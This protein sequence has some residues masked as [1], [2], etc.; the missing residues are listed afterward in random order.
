M[1]V[2]VVSNLYPPIAFGGYEILCQQIVELLRGRGLEVDVLTSRFRAEDAPA[3]PRVERSLELTTDFPRPGEDVRFVDF[4]L[5]TI[6]RVARANEAL[7]GRALDRLSLGPMFAARRR[8]V[9][10]CY[11][12]NDEHPKQFRWNGA[13]S[14]ARER[15]R[16]IA[17]RTLWRKATLRDLDPVPTAVISQA[18]KDA[19]LG[20]GTPI[21]HAQVIHQGIPLNRF[22]FDPAPRRDGDPLR[23]LYVGQLSELKGVHTLIRAMGLL[24][25]G[26]GD[27]FELTVV[28][29]GVPEYVARL[30]GLVQ[31]YGLQGVVRFTGR[32]A[33]ADVAEAYRSHHV[34]VFATEGREAF[35]LSHLEAMASGCAVVSTTR[36]GCA[37]LVRDGLNAREFEAGN[38]LHLA[39][40]LRLLADDEEARRQ[41]VTNGRAWV[42]AHHDLDHYCARLED[43]MAR[44]LRLGRSSF[45]SGEG[46]E[47]CPSEAQGE[48]AR[49]GRAREASGEGV[50]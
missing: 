43:F 48:S 31:E 49:Q 45:A 18:L 23:V 25:G 44:A 24:H 13:P 14:S 3:D 38:A 21:S 10:V 29:S 41:L 33:H 6:H 8:D 35:G 12:V 26:G 17:E 42:E 2:L 9:P 46:R 50:G 22:P 39:S 34:L 1:K 30:E 32:V 20:Q 40:R 7:T 4:R 47:R 16:A 27:R 36:G 28:G 5:R 37:E 19:L 11:T 15:L